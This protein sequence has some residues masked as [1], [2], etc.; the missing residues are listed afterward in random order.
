MQGGTGFN[1][2]LFGSE[3][4]VIDDEFGHTDFRSRQKLTAAVKNFTAAGSQRCHGKGKE[5]LTLKPFWRLSISVNDEPE[6][7]L[8]LPLMDDSV[9]DK[10]MIFKISNRPMP[11]PT[12]TLEETDA[13]WKQLMAEFPAFLHHLITLQVPEAMRSSRYGVRHFHHPEVME[14]IDSLSP[15]AKLLS[16]LDDYFAPLATPWTGTADALQR[17]LEA[18]GSDNQHEARKLFSFNTACGN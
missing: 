17:L 16:M 4:L 13:F 9:A 12:S 5:A 10:M 18:E 6:S 3:H 14:A 11:M 2:E 1:S 15:E 7:L 8:V